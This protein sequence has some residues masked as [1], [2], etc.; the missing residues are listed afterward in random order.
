MP[1][2]EVLAPLFA[3]FIFAYLYSQEHAKDIKVRDILLEWVWLFVSMALIVFSFF[4]DYILSSATTDTISGI[5]T[6]IYAISN[7]LNSFGLGLGS[8]FIFLICYF[9]WRLI[10]YARS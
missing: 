9:A 6:Y 1:V 2:Q 8:L 5:T 3:G 4:N 10:H 7:N